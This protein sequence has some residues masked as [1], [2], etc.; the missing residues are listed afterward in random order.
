VRPAI[1]RLDMAGS[2]SQ[3][4][5]GAGVATSVPLLGQIPPTAGDRWLAL[6]IDP[7]NPPL[8][9]RVAFAC[10]TMGSPVVDSSYAGLVIDEWL[11]RIPSTQEQA[12]V[13][14]HFNEPDARAPQSLLLAVCPDARATW[15]DDLI[16]GTLQETFDLAKIRTVDLDSIQ[17]VGQILPAL[18][19]PFN[20]RGATVGSNYTVLKDINLVATNIRQ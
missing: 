3:L 17:Q 4:L 15:D 7:A 16:L 10:V 6:P 2:L 19:F 20:L 1:S 18:Y 11:E 13:A 5:G 14:F 9:G 8:K 12:A